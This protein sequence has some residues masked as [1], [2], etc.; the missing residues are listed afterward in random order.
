[1]LEPTDEVER[2][3]RPRILRKHNEKLRSL[4][5]RQSR[6]IRKQSSDGISNCAE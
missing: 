2:W 5:W 3:Q 6:D 4:E 1:M